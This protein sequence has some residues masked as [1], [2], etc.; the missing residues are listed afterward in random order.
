V[1]ND[2]TEMIEPLVRPLLGDGERLLVAAPQ[3]KDP[4]TTEDVS[5]SDE[6]KNLLDPTILLGLGAH[7]GGLLQR[8]TFGRALVGGA[9]SIAKAVY[10]SAGNASHLAVTDRRLL[11]LR[12]ELVYPPGTGFWRRWFGPS[13]EVVHGLH[14]VDRHHI[15]K[16][17]PAPAGVLRRGR[18]LVV[19]TDGSMCALVGSPP[20]FGRRLAAV[21]GEPR[22]EGRGD[23]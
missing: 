1:G 10:D 3:V 19:F 15:V 11:I 5:V 17:V 14:H 13:Q 2:Y 8:A 9:G 4:G 6:L 7:P 21:L 12:T 22:P 23:G 18:F 16:T 20:K